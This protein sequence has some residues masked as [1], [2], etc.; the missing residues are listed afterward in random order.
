MTGRLA[1]VLALAALAGCRTLPVAPVAAP[2]EAARAAIAALADWQA[3][4]RVAVRAGEQGF[5]A[6]FEWREA[7]GAGDIGV[8][9]P[10]GAGAVR[11]HRTAE[12]I[13]IESGNAAP[14]E[15]PAPFTALE[16]ELIARLGFPL[17]L[18]RLRFWVRGVPDPGFPATPVADG[19]VQADWQVTVLARVA[20]AG[21]PG[22]LPGRLTLSREATR[23]RVLVDHW[24]VGAP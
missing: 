2:D 5:N 12:A 18:D 7:G 16:P 4:G 8:H 19:F 22:A 11:I 13:R 3:S 21:A 14:L 17:P 10:L 6:S 9:G 15:V 24:R 1:A 20:V 23:I